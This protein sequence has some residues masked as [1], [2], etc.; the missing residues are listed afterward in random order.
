VCAHAPKVWAALVLVSHLLV[1][2]L[3]AGPTVQPIEDVVIKAC[4]ANDLPNSCG[5]NVFTSCQDGTVHL[6]LGHSDETLLSSLSVERDSITPSI[7]ASSSSLR[8]VVVETISGQKVITICPRGKQ[9]G[10]T[11]VTIKVTDGLGKSITTD[12]AIIVQPL[13]P[14]LDDVGPT[15]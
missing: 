6:V 8:D 4:S 2:V 5:Q 13:A 11:S 7:S 9:S 1:G 15:R 3:G 10:R 12:F 14:V